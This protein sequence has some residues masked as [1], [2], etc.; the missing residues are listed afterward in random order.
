[1]LMVVKQN[2]FNPPVQWVKQLLNEGKLGT[3]FA[4]QINGFWNRNATY[5][6]DDWHGTHQLDGG[7]LFTQFSHFIDVICWF[8]GK[9]EVLNAF[10]GN[11]THTGLI[12]FEDTGMVQLQFPNGALGSLQYT[13]SAFEQNMEGSITLF[14][15]KGT[16]KIGGAYLNEITYCHIKEVE[17]PQ[18]P[19]GNEANQY[20]GGIQ[21][22]MN[23]HHQV[24]KNFVAALNGEEEL[25]T[26]VK[27]ALDTVTLIEA[28]YEAAARSVATA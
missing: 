2:R 12:E 10:T 5:Y 28:I 22:S 17:L 15:T 26:T 27:E 19:K 3:I 20:S 4:A 25:V 13:V 16:V 23:N 8:L 14:G 21:G 11:F 1:L 6:N 9:P 24:Y 7:T 18:L